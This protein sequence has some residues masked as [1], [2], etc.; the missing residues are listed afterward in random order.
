MSPNII[1][2]VIRYVLGIAVVTGVGL[3]TC[4]CKTSGH[5]EFDLEILVPELNAPTTTLDTES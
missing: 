5:I 3:L 1:R 4:G 2:T